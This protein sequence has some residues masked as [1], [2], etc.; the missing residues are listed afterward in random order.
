MQTILLVDDS[1][2]IRAQLAKVLSGGGYAVLTAADGKLAIGLLQT[3]QV[4]LVV[5]DIFM[6]EADGLE[7]LI[8]LQKMP[9]RP[10]V[11]AMSS[12]TG[13]MDMLRSAKILGAKKILRKPFPPDELLQHA[14]ALLG[15]AA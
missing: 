10:P 15:A 6:P 4:D 9:E 7:V 13:S 14:K 2:S 11:I 8:A 12:K 5:T 3:Q 1:E